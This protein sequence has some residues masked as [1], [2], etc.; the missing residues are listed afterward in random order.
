M[1][2]TFPSKDSKTTLAIISNDL[3]NKKNSVAEWDTVQ[4]I[5]PLLTYYTKKIS[6]T[7]SGD[8]CCILKK[9]ENMFIVYLDLFL[10]QTQYHL[11]WKFTAFWDQEVNIA[12]YKT[13]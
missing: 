5:P 2:V 13:Y 3:K 7:I 12:K 10:F 11:E 9:Y 8:F 4:L 6:V 1:P